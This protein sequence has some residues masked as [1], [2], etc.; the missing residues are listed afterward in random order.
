VRVTI[1]AFF[2]RFDRQTP[3]GA[4][5]VFMG[6]FGN[7][8]TGVKTGKVSRAEARGSEGKDGECNTGLSP[9]GLS[10][11]PERG[12]R[13]LCSDNAKDRLVC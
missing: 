10:K 12:V 3:F 5:I 7:T 9:Q 6:R 2:V 13:A 11:L 1:A 4:F 8:R